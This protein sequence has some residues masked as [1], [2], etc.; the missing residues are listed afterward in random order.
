MNSK[1]FIY[2]IKNLNES[3]P[4]ISSTSS[5]FS[6]VIGFTLVGYYTDILL[7]T[8]PWFLLVCLFLGVFM[9]LYNIYKIVNKD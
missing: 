8:S 6:Y 2:F 3:G 1:S 7:D 5:L 9:G 4:I